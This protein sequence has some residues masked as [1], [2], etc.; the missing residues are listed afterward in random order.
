[1]RRWA[2]PAT[3]VAA[4]VALLIL[5]GCVTELEQGQEPL[6][7]QP[8]AIPDSQPAG[9]TVEVVQVWPHAYLKDTNNNR[10][11]DRISTMVYFWT[12]SYKLPIRAHGT[13]CFSL[14]PSG[15]V[16]RTDSQPICEWVFEG[17][18]LSRYVSRTSAGD[19]YYFELSLLQANGQDGDDL[20]MKS[21]D[22]VATFTA[23][24]GAEPVSSG[25]STVLLQPY[26]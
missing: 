22:L 24:D 21:A 14:Y 19:G 20:G 7:P 18:A 10:V 26:P 4:G 16:G 11:G 15:T 23:N 12:R 17:D 8:A 13:L 2:I 6:R 9:L 5:T 3:V 1:M 25:V